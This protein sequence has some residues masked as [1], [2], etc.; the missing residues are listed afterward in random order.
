MG[1]EARH[2]YRFGYLKSEHWQNLRIQKLAEQDAKCHFCNHRDI[3]NDVHHI[4]YPE[5]LYKTR[6]GVLCVL[7]RKHHDRLHSLMDEITA[8]LEKSGE[9]LG[10]TKIGC[11]MVLF[12][13]ASL[14]I[15]SEMANEGMKRYTIGGDRFKNSRHAARLAPPIPPDAVKFPRKIGKLILRLEDMGRGNHLSRESKERM[16]E[17]IKLLRRVSNDSMA[18]MKIRYLGYEADFVRNET[19]G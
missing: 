11:D 13:R 9:K 1:I 8:N 17:A 3:S 14:I 12:K 10:N 15:E 4:H 19:A 5:N 18:E 7:C 2:A 16:D 6:L